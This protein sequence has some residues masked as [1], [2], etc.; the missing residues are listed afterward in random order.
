MIEFGWGLVFGL[1]YVVEY[2]LEMYG[3]YGCM[4]ILMLSD[5]GE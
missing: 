1:G 3:G 2:C 4:F 5:F